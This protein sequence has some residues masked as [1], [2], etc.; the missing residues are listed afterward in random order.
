MMTYETQATSPNVLPVEAKTVYLDWGAI[1]AGIIFAS[2]MSIVLLAFGSGLG[3]AFASISTKSYALGAGIGAALWFIWVEVSSFM[4]GGY[5]AGRLRRS[6]RSSSEHET[7]V[8]D[9]SH[10]LV[11]WA[12][13]VVVG[14]FLA[15]SSAGSLVNS[16]GNIAKSAAEVT[17]TTAQ[18]VAPAAMQY[19]SDSLLR[20]ATD[21][22]TATVGS[23]KAAVTS[24]VSAILTRS[25]LAAPTDEDKTYLAQVVAKQTGVTPDEA[26]T[27]VDQT[28]ASIEK[29]KAD[30]AQTAETARKISVIAAFLLAASLLISAVAAFWAASVG[31]RHKDEAVEFTGFFRVK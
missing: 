19:Y 22:T 17:A 7:E 27:R 8:R 2:A 11:V 15:L 6:L 3:L 16:A 24:E 4:A 1:I 5:L 21:N 26:K 29:A 31:G 14:A 9:G 23:D 13:C 20:P 18:G 28:Y 30:V 25:S 12:G 10:G